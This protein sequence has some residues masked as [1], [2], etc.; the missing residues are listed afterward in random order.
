MA[1]GQAGVKV[2]GEASNGREAVRL[3]EQLQPS[4]RAGASMLLTEDGA[5]EPLHVATHKAVVPTFMTHCLLKSAAA[6]REG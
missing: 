2:G 6:Q 1:D 5:M 3:M 4:K